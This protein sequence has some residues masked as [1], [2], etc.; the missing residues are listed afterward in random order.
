MRKPVNHANTVKTPINKR[1]NFSKI[2]IA[3]LKYIESLTEL[4]KSKR[5]GD[6]V[7]IGEKLK[8]S[9]Q[10][11]ETAYYRVYQKNHFEVVEELKA[12]INQRNK[13]IQV[14]E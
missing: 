6:W 9:A 11:A 12:I 5:R 14:H 3:E 1:F 13:L 7:K 8:I 10:C 2:T 4:L